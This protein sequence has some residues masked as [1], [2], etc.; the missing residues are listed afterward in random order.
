MRK[1][2]K[3]REKAR[4]KEIFEIR[5]FS[6]IITKSARA[7]KYLDIARLHGKGEK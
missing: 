2:Q 1:F 3:N 5:I 4:K 7:Q 6:E